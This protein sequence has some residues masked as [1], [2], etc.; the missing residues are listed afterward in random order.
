MFLCF[1]FSDFSILYI[2]SFVYTVYDDLTG[3]RPSP[4]H[5]GESAAHIHTDHTATETASGTPQGLMLVHK[6]MLGN[7][8]AELKF[9]NACFCSYSCCFFFNLFLSGYSRTD[10]T[11]SNDLR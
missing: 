4:G 10:P 9:L 6:H 11:C 8:C 1:V 7:L 3:R 5:S 2:H